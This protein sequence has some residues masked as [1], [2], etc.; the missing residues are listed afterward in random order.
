MERHHL[1]HNVI[2]EAPAA[3]RKPVL[4]LA[5]WHTFQFFLCGSAASGYEG[6]RRECLRRSFQSLRNRGGPYEAC[7]RAVRS[8]E[9]YG[10]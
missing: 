8:G 5:G 2:A 1:I 7:W 4:S 10:P 9:S 3:Q 6:P